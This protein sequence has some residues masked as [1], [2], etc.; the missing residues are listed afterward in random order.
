M[1]L[2]AIPL[3]VKVLRQFSNSKL[4]IYGLGVAIQDLLN[5]CLFAKDNS[6]DVVFVTIL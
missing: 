5:L 2:P 4:K 1:L 6:K 3:F